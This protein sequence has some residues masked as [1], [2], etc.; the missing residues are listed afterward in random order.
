[1][2]RNGQPLPSASSSFSLHQPSAKRK[3]IRPH[4]EPRIDFRRV[5]IRIHVFFEWFDC[6]VFISFNLFIMSQLY[7]FWSAVFFFSRTLGN[8]FAFFKHVLGVHLVSHTFIFQPFIFPF[9]LNSFPV[10]SLQRIS[11]MSN[12]NS[13]DFNVFLYCLFVLAGLS[14]KVDPS[15]AAKFISSKKSFCLMR[16][17]KK[18]GVLSLRFPEFLTKIHT[19]DEKFLI[20]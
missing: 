7:V 6:L 19:I 20:F 3:V 4:H 9:S 16:F 10:A 14:K 2:H 12:A 13:N 5:S 11:L 15:L 18:S 17:L 8:K 1:M